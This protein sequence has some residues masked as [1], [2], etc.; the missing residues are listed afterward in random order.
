M[1]KVASKNVDKYNLVIDKFLRWLSKTYNLD[2]EDELCIEVKR[3]NWCNK[4]NVTKTK[5]PNV[6]EVSTRMLRKATI[7]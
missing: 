2:N 1:L 4:T 7:K 3:L 5:I 6:S